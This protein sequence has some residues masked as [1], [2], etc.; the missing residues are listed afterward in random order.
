MPRPNFK[1][2]KN[3]NDGGINLYS[4]EEISV[5][6]VRKTQLI[7]TFGIGSIVDFKD[8]TVV[9]ASTDSWDWNVNNIQEIEK[10]KIFNENLSAI[11]GADHFLSPKTTSK[12]NSFSKPKD[13]LSYI[14]P[15]ML[16][17]SKCGLIFNINELNIK[18]RHTCPRCKGS[19]TASRF[20][21]VCQN[22]HMDDFPYDWWVHSG[23]KCKSGKEAPRIKMINVNNRTD[24]ASLKLICTECGMQRSMLHVFSSNALADFKC[25][26]SHPHFKYKKTTNSHCDNPVKVML[27]ASSGVYFPITKSALLIPPWSKKAVSY[28]QM[29]YNLLKDIPSEKIA[30]KVRI[31]LNDSRIADDEIMRSWA[32][33]SNR[34]EN[35]QI[36]SELSIMNDEY[37]VLSNEENEESEGFSSY[38][39]EIP[40]KYKKYFSQI[41]VVDR[42]TVTQAL[43]G[44]T[45]LIRN[46]AFKV[47][48]SQSKKNWYPAVEMNGEGIFIRFNKEKIERWV[49]LN[50]KRYVLMKERMNKSN[51]K[52]EGFSSMY[53]LIHSFAHLFIREI[54]NVCGYNAA[55]I[56]EKIYSDI[57]SE[58]SEIKMCGVLIYVS[59]SDSEG[60]LGG[61][62][63]IAYDPDAMENILDNMLKRAMWCS[64]D[65]LCITSQNQGFQN[66]NYAACHDC[67]L[68]PETSCERFNVF[69]DRAS[70]I[71]LE[72]DKTL[73]Y[74]NTD[75]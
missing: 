3:D 8:D 31:G 55:S 34:M 58:T 17:C 73:G 45:R 30:E 13:V 60:S 57:D 28:I 21:I 64:G 10:R 23:Q 38:N 4:E 48:V 75:F 27:R 50:F 52:Y 5:G 54:S 56:K 26:C 24:I 43:V 70:I 71:G 14:F 69:L 16:H 35:K 61:L 32:T 74:F 63:S 15:E 12:T 37:A 67:M 65:P 59:S 46:E 47:N 11:T 53:I 9:I 66:L 68:L 7:T 44:F 18:E 2:K 49:K 20:I 29:N 22:G 6:S 62:I 25:T 19:L 72:D 42:L 1:K 41:S 33:V 36:R 40:E 51:F 39:S